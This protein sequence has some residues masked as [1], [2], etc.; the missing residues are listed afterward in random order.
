MGIFE[1][2]GVLNPD[3]TVT[4]EI[5]NGFVSDVIKKLSKGGSTIPGVQLGPKIEPTPGAQQ[6]DL[7]NKNLFPDFHEVWRP[8]YEAMVKGIDAEGAYNLNKYVPF[9]FDPTAMAATLGATPP[10]MKMAD[11]FT[12]MLNPANLTPPLFF[13]KLADPQFTEVEKLPEMSAEEY[14]IAVAAK[15]SESAG[16]LFEALAAPPIPPIPQIPD[17]K[18]QELGYTEQYTNEINSALSP[19]LAYPILATGAGAVDLVGA[20]GGSITN[21]PELPAKVLEAV[22]KQNIK[23]APPS[24]E[25]SSFE[26]AVN[27]TFEEHRAKYTAATM[28][29]QNIGHGTIVDAMS[30]TPFDQ[31]GFEIIREPEE[32]EPAATLFKDPLSS[33]RYKVLQIIEN[34]LGK[35]PNS[36]VSNL[37]NKEKFKEL[38]NWEVPGEIGTALDVKKE[39]TLLDEQLKPYTS[40]PVGQ[41]TSDEKNAAEQIQQKINE[42]NQQI[43]DLMAK[44]KGKPIATTCNAFPIFI[45]RKLGIK[46]SEYVFKQNGVQYQLLGGLDT[47]RQA[48]RLKGCWVDAMSGPDRTWDPSV[49]L[50][51]EGDIFLLSMGSHLF[52][53]SAKPDKLREQGSE[54]W[55]TDARHVGIFFDLVGTYTPEDPKNPVYWLTADAG[56]GAVASGEQKA[57]YVNRPV[58]VPD[59]GGAKIIVKGEPDIFGNRK[60]AFLAG[61]LD[62]DKLTIADEAQVF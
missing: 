30:A 59:G 11:A 35:P 28:V 10:P 43:G 26:I 42:K 41:L 52:N 27:S 9:L 18:L 7:K 56:Q 61:W 3:G 6:L 12:E 40:K 16:K 25:T 24:M 54:P 33:R 23:F 5:W 37:Q 51:K 34:W 48:A 32:P 8:R 2:Q 31:G 57:A 22:G 1:K 58:I 49:G 14:D 46:E 60:D 19:V 39:K 53:N 17:P 36:F 47:M 15:E 38:T 4:D 21:P 45:M 13:I 44:A 20:I 50:P 55:D 62:I 29:A